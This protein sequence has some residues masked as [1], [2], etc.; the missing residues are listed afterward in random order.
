MD[1]QRQPILLPDDSA[2]EPTDRMGLPARQLHEL[3]DRQAGFLAQEANDLF[4]LADRDGDA[5]ARIIETRHRGRSG[6]AS[7]SGA[8]GAGQ[9]A[10]RYC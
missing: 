7:A 9:G 6:D 8:A 1:I 3:G 4:R 10:G 5:L 2:E